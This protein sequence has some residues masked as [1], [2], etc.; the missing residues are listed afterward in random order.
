ME[1]FID[2]GI[3]FLMR[4]EKKL[5]DIFVTESA[6]LG[7]KASLLRSLIFARTDD[8]SIR[9]EYQTLH[10]RITTAITQRNIVIH[11][12]WRSD[13]VGNDGP[14]KVRSTVAAVRKRN[15]QIKVNGGEVKL[16]AKGLSDRSVE[17]IEFFRRHGAFLE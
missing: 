15:A 12:V 5:V 10:D 14:Y 2:D 3:L 11:G 9:A 16:V 8:E 6:T 17:L 1:E 7:V 13:E 4:S